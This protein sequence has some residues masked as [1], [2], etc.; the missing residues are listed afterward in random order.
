MKQL[1]EDEIDVIL[2]KLD[3]DKNGTIEY[4][5]FLAHSLNKIDHLSVPNV[6]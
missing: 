5:E 1:T 3:Q 4:Q 6:L 2:E